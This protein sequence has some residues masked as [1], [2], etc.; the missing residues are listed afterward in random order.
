MTQK[1]R[2][3]V[4][5]YKIYIFLWCVLSLPLVTEAKLRKE[6]IRNV[7]QSFAINAD[8]TT[9]ITNKYGAVNI[10]TWD[11]NEVK[12]DIKITVKAKT[13]EA[14]EETFDRI[15]FDFDDRPDY[16]QAVTN[17]ESQKSNSWIS[18]FSGS[19]N[20]SEFTID[21]EVK[22]PISNNLKLA[23]KYG[24]SDVE[25]IDG[26]VEAYIKYGKVRMQ[27]IGGNLNLTLGYG[28]GNILTAQDATFDVKYSRLTVKKL[29]D[30]DLTTKYSKMYIDEAR[31]FKTL[32]K[33]DTYEV[34]VV[35]D[36]SC[37]SKYDK[38]NFESAYEVDINGKYSDYTFG[39]VKRRAD[40]LLSYGGTRINKLKKGFQE[41]RIDGSYANFK[42]YPEVGCSYHLSGTAS[43]GSISYPDDMDVI[44][45]IDKNTSSEVEGYVGSKSTD[46]RIKLNIRYG[47]VKILE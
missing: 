32:S 39:E 43:Y 10:E 7:N 42:I 41:L 22:M 35:K 26:S 24:D 36:F 33:Y 38:Y 19:N 45:R 28:T 18:W 37:I 5:Q 34:G 3:M 21:Y 9:D 4:N 20:N 1:K 31:N 44:K 14:A 6:F 11:R 25:S 17:I 13:E 16:V 47:G 30:V 27:D 15:S 8:G 2:I 40:I 23:N 29:N 12:I 46:T